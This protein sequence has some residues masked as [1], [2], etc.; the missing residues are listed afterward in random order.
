MK[1]LL[2]NIDYT[3]STRKFYFDSSIKNKI[4]KFNPEEK[5]IHQL[6]KEICEAECMSV[7]YNAK[8]KGNVYR[9]DEEG[10]SK[11]IGYMYRGKSEIHDRSMSKPQIG[12][13][14]IWATIHEV[15]DFEFE[16]LD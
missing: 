5:S 2:I 12:Y 13:F 10:N 1:T 8:P 9:D 7:S 14:D 6:I 11:I 4:I 16:E 3:D 15:I